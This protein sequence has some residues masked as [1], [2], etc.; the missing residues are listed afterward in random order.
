[1]RFSPFPS[2][3]HKDPDTSDIP[4][5][6]QGLTASRR[7]VG[8]DIGAGNACCVLHSKIEGTVE[9]C[10]CESRQES[11]GHGLP[12]SSAVNAASSQML[13]GC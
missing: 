3:V 13:G 5:R 2:P 9:S 10:V 8:G 1:M 12:S 4:V 6:W 11:P 7:V